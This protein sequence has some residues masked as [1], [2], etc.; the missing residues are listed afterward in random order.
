MMQYLEIK[1][2]GIFISQTMPAAMLTEAVK[3]IESTV[4]EEGDNF[5]V[6]FHDGYM[7]VSG[8][9][10]VS[11]IQ[12]LVCGL[13]MIEPYVEVGSSIDIQY[14]TYPEVTVCLKSEGFPFRAKAV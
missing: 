13:N 7:Q 4:T 14:G 11:D 9:G 2:E 12:P 3:L 6:L 8:E 5:E 1:S 10:V